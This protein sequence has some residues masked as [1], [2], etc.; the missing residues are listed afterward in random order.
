MGLSGCLT[1]GCYCSIVFIDKL[2]RRYVMLRTLPGMGLCMFVVGFC[3][4]LNIN[5]YECGKWI[6]AVCLLI[7]LSMYAIG[8]GATPNIINSEIYPIHLRGIG[9][10]MGAMGTWLSNYL[11]SALFLTATETDLGEVFDLKY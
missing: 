2:G 7:Y 4:W 1:L 3:V 5:G 8:M 11:I 6:L 10:S 9:N